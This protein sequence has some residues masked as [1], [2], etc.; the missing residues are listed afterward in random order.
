M[1]Y[2]DTYYFANIVEKVIKNSFDYLRNLESW[3]GGDITFSYVAPFRKNSNLHEFIDFVLDTVFF[4]EMSRLTLENIRVRKFDSKNEFRTPIEELFIKYELSYKSFEEWSIENGLVLNEESMSEEEF[5]KYYEYSSELIYEVR[6]NI[7]E[8]VFYILFL[9]REFLQEFN[10]FM[11]DYLE[12]EADNLTEEK[13][14]TEDLDKIVRKSG[15]LYR[16]SIP[17]WVKKAV[18]YRD[19]GRCCYCNKDL[20]GVISLQSNKNYDHIIPLNQ[21]GFNDVTNIQLLCLECNS[22]KSGDNR[23]VSINYEKWY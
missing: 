5:E 1:R 3:I 20:S 15:K 2:V 10:S 6:Q 17:Q 9:N 14:K 18:F 23:K 13:I 8:E 11:A 16:P 19:R 7:T 22:E 21:F 4:E 12:M